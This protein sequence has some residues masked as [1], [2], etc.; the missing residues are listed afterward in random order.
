MAQAHRLRL[1]LSSLQIQTL[2]LSRFTTQA[3]KFRLMLGLSDVEACRL[4]LSRLIL[5][6]AYRLKLSKHKGSGF[7]EGLS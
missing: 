1:K 6:Q 4:R 7:C 3:H 2:K 5:S